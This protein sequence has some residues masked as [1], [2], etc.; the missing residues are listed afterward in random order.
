MKVI[1][2][3]DVKD[4]GKV[5]E[6]V[7]VKAGFARNFLFPRHLAVEATEKR[8]KEF[9]HLKAV[10]EAQK[11]K[12]V[13]M[14]KELLKEIEGLTVEFVVEA[15]EDEKLFGSI[16][17]LDISRKLE[18]KGYQIDKRDILL[19]EP[20]KMLGQFKAQVT[21]GEELTADITV[22]VNRK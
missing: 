6:L 1:L 13:E 10:A 4:L 8:K 16:S 17:N 9:E 19:E 5:G 2:N 3:K 20:I 14:R 15:S 22:S 21:F 7:S 18:D 12:A 11:E